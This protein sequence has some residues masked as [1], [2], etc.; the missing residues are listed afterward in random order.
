MGLPNG[1]SIHKQVSTFPPNITLFPQWVL[2]R[3]RELRNIPIFALG[4][5]KGR[6]A[7]ELNVVI[8]LDAIKGLVPAD[9]GEAL[10]DG[11][12]GAHQVLEQ[13][14]RFRRQTAI[15][16]TWLAFAEAENQR[17]WLR[18]FRPEGRLR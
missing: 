12:Y 1:C 14:R 5:E 6:A 11:R 13:R 3:P 4:V 18:T 17:A 2:V 15:Y 7:F 9:M 10:C 16:S 8:S